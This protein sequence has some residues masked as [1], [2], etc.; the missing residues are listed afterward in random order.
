MASCT[1]YTFYTVTVNIT[2]KNTSNEMLYLWFSGESMDSDKLT[3]PNGSRSR[4]FNV[5]YRMSGDLSSEETAN[6]P[7]YAQLIAYCAHSDADVV[8]QELSVPYYRGKGATVNIETD[9]AR[10]KVDMTQN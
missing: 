1:E 7:Q 8:G 4:S 10:F 5:P 2:M 9:G 6:M 3:A